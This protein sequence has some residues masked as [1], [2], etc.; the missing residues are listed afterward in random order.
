MPENKM[1]CGHLFLRRQDLLTLWV[2]TVTAG[3]DA[4]SHDHRTWT[5]LFTSGKTP[6][7]CICFFSACICAAFFIA[8]DT[9]PFFSFA[10]ILMSLS[11]YASC[12]VG[13]LYPLPKV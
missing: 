13:G 3:L 4:Y 9:D 6:I 8:H 2:Q 11:S 12:A 10:L 5:L 1:C 7:F